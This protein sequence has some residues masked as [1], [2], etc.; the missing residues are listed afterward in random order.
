MVSIAGFQILEN[1]VMSWYSQLPITQAFKG[2][3]KKF[4]FR[5]IKS[6][7]QI[8]RNKERTVFTV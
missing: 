8:T 4:K 1:W 7:E 5:V 6:S 3:R 2:N